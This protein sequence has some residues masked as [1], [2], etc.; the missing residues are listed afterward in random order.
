MHIQQ[1][2][3]S[4][5]PFLFRRVTGLLIGF[6]VLGVLAA[7][8]LFSATEPKPP[9]IDVHLHAFPADFIGRVGAPNPVT[10]KPSEATTDDELL[11]ASFAEMNRANIVKAIVSDS[12]ERPSFHIPLPC[13][14]WGSCA[15]ISATI[16]S[17]RWE[18]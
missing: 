6:A 2:A 5:P 16:S 18:R 10:G 14:S 13:R 15:T 3:A 7:T 8:P 1:R 17:A 12:W 9:I 4:G 11:K